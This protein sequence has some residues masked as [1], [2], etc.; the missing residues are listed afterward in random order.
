MS[1]KKINLK[2]T[3]K[4]DMMAKITETLAAAGIEILTGT[5]FGFTTTTLVARTA[6][7]D[8]QIKLITPKAGVTRYEELEVE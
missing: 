7:T 4:A 2:D 8:I 6:D 3:A 5:D 1:K